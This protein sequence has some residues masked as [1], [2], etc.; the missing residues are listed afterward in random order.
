MY[1][2]IHSSGIAQRAHADEVRELLARYETL[3]GGGRVPSY[4]ELNLATLDSY[5][6]NLLVLMPHGSGDFVYL[7]YG[8]RVAEQ[9]GHNLT[10][11][12]LSESGSEVATYFTAVYDRAR[13]ERRPLYSL[14]RS[15]ATSRI[16]IWERLILPLKTATGGD[17]LIVYNSAV[18]MKDELLGAILDSSPDG[19]VAFR[20]VYDDAGD[21]VDA[22]VVTANRRVAELAGI[23]LD[24]LVDAR[25]R[26]AFAGTDLAEKWGRFRNVIATKAAITF[27]IRH[28]LHDEPHWFRVHARPLGDGFLINLSDITELKNAYHAL[29]THAKQL[30]DEVGQERRT[31]EALVEEISAREMIESELRRIADADTLTGI[32]NR[33]SFLECTERGAAVARA[34]G[35]GLALILVD[36]DHFKV[37]NDTYGHGAGDA[38]IVSVV[39]RL[40]SRIRSADLI[41]RIGGEEFGICLARVGEE[42]A[43]RI[44][45]TL[46]RALHDEPILLP[47]GQALAVSASF[48]VAM[49]AEHETVP[50]LLERADRALY[51]AK[52]AGRNCIVAAQAAAAGFPDDDEALPFATAP[53]A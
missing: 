27:E 52:Q 7:H 44:A 14:H 41:G 30:A 9:S 25:L 13:H 1:R 17:I 8:R 15:T 23:P 10:G 4:A 26:Q 42:A 39:E 3:A 48:G 51:G 16:L 20:P 35:H 2:E 12:R 45:E 53:A 37:V 43:L 22:T 47:E 40:S 21:I 33:R 11:T 5:R 18:Q 36:I 6:D 32:L 50:A 19:I 49:L 31:R 46:R 28:A 34:K 38:V 24:R 29:E